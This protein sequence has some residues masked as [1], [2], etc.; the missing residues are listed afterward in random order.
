MRFLNTEIKNRSVLASGILGLSAA[1]LGRVYREGAAIVTSKSIGPVQ[2]K[3]HNA[4]VVFDWGGGLIN[5]VG[6]SNPGVDAFIS[7][8]DRCD[9][10]FPFILSIYGEKEED[11][12]SLA[13]KLEVLKPNFIEL[14]LSCP[15]VLTELG[16]PFGYSR[17]GTG[18]IIRSVKDATDMP[19][20]A[21]L[22]PN[23]S[24]LSQVAK[25]AEEN[26]ADALCI[27]NSVGP[28]MVID[29]NTGSPVLGNQMG[30]VSGKAI[31]PLTIKNVFE[32][33]Q[34]V[35]IPIIGTGGVTD[36]DSALQVLMAGAEMYGI[37]SAIYQQGVDIFQKIADGI[38]T[39]MTDNN[40][41]DSAE[42]IGMATK[43]KSYS[44]HIAEHKKNA[45]KMVTLPI[46]EIED[47]GTMRTIY[48]DAQQLLYYS[49][50]PA[51]PKPGQFYMLWIPGVDQKPYSVSFYDKELIGFTCK[52]RGCFS[53]RLFELEKGAPIGLLGPLGK[54]FDLS[55]K[56][57][58]VVGG[59]IGAAPLIFA[60]SELVKQG[61]H[62][63]LFIGGRTEES[64]VWTRHL[65]CKTPGADPRSITFCTDDGHLGIKGLATDHLYNITNMCHP[66]YVLICGPEIFT[67]KAITVLDRLH[68]EGQA[69][70][71]RMMKCGV[72]I[73]GSC[74]VDHTG[75]RVCKEG[76]IFE[77][78]YLRKMKEF[79]SY[80]MDETGGVVQQPQH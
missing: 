77:F 8:F 54:S 69:S 67:Q 39:Y 12:A 59:G 64:T 26:G 28:G 32:L 43:P 18:R 19:I 5:A 70:I 79:G 7:Q 31:L 75:D 42:L 41:T 11:F 74:S 80:F 45:A 61:K 15:N 29:T 34:A 37:G 24:K 53:Q 71:E 52:K 6:L 38:E 14:N 51:E 48:F 49:K 25:A 44:F 33:S 56:K 62:V 55:H 23:T 78:S 60:A 57:Y 2:R 47:V 65:F 66:S 73:C 27:M 68:K 36:T 63:D 3:G 22:S 72:G 50:D 21:K 1:A 40:I 17:S 35:S 76:P 16:T 30:G 9:I 13:Q 4:P 46:V 20:V 58:L 10:D